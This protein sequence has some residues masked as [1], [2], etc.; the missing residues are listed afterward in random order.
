MDIQ[1]DWTNAYT[2]VAT[3]T[4]EC[5]SGLILFP[6][7]RKKIHILTWFLGINLMFVLVYILRPQG[8]WGNFLAVIVEL[9][10]E[11]AMLGVFFGGSLWKNTL[12]HYININVINRWVSADSGN[13]GGHA[14]D[15]D[16]AGGCREGWYADRMHHAG[17]NGA[18]QSDFPEN[19]P[20]RGISEKRVDL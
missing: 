17:G 19:L 2:I 5:L 12:V 18:H 1:I 13:E 11:I 8:V 20:D 4:M 16:R 10:G 15:Q 7:K 9:Y 3:A 6:F 14:A